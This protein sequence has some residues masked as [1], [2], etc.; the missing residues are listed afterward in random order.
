M[1]YNSKGSKLED[2]F[3]SCSKDHVT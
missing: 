2:C 3:Y 1:D